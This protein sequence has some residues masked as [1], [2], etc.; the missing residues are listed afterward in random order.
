MKHLISKTFL[1]SL[2]ALAAV[3]VLNVNSQA[4]TN[5]SQR[6]SFESGE[7]ERLRILALRLKPGQD[8]RQQLESF[9]KEAAN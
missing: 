9:V 2:T 7:A 4:Q 5:R 1:L 3:L 8:L 6:Q